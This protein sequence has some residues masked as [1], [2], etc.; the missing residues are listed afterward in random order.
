ML[1]MLR[2]SMQLD[3]GAALLALV[4]TPGRAAHTSRVGLKQLPSRS[5]AQQCEA[6]F[7]EQAQDNIFENEEKESASL[8]TIL[9]AISGGAGLTGEV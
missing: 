3:V 9:F 8:H 1:W 5:S 7:E 4:G 6:F 2:N